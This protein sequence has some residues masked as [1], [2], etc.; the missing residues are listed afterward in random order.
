MLRAL[1]APH[2]RFCASFYPDVPEHDAPGTSKIIGAVLW[3]CRKIDRIFV[4]NNKLERVSAELT[5]ISSVAI[6]KL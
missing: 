5:F 1:F 2:N 4:V 6:I 3:R